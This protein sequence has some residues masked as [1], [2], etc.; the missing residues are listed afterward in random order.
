M[1]E[2]TD[3]KKHQ[4]LQKRALAQQNGGGGGGDD[5]KR[6]RKPRPLPKRKGGGGGKKRK[7]ACWNCGAT[8]HGLGAGGSTLRPA[9]MRPEAASSAPLSPSRPKSSAKAEA[10]SIHR[11][12]T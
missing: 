4:K 9:S 2:H 10:V 11:L 8:D 5:K 7:K 3:G 1:K 12:G 6:K